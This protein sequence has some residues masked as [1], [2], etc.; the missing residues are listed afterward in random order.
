MS[1]KAL[2]EHKVHPEFHHMMPQ[3]ENHTPK[4]TAL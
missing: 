4:E 2:P 1:T 3:N